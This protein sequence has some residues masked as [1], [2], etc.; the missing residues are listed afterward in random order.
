VTRRER[1]GGSAEVS[2][3]PWGTGRMPRTVVRMAQPRAAVLRHFR[4]QRTC[5]MAFACGEMSGAQG[6]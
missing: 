6:S 1:Q 4:L 3:R 5:G 2:R